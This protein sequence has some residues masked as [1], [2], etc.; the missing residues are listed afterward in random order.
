MSQSQNTRFMELFR[1]EAGPSGAMS[2]ERFMQLALFHPELG[3]YRRQ[4]P[5]VGYGEGT[6]FFTSSTSGPV[7]GEMVACACATLLTKRGLHPADYQFVEVG[8]ESDGG[9]LTGVAHPFGGATTLRLGSPLTLSGNCI[10]FSNEL[11]D[12]QPCRSFVRRGAEWIEL[13]VSESKGALCEVEIGPVCEDWLPAEVG[14][15]YRFDAPRAA[16]DLLRSLAGQSWK[17]LFVAADYGKS[18]AELSE[19][20]PVGTLRAYHRH[21][22]NNDLLARPG[23]QDLTCH[24]CWDWMRD[25]LAQEGFESPKVVAQETFLV[26]NAGDFIARCVVEEAARLSHRKLSIAQLLHPAH[27]G[28]KFQVLHGFR[29]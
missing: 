18:F 8:S 1:A 14:E 9:I 10:V 27:L 16:L 22:Q 19:S 2:F 4:E 21:A 26:E 15:G 23:E 5:R 7:F 24:L 11:F 17:G 29:F 28:R 20:C 12:A 13:G 6:D 25:G 3:Y